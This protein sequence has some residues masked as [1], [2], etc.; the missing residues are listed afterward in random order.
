MENDRETQSIMMNIRGAGAMM[1]GILLFNNAAAVGTVMLLSTFI[2]RLANKKLLKP[3]E[4]KNLDA[5]IRKTGGTYQIYNIPAISKEQLADELTKSGLQFHVLPDLNKNDGIIQVAIDKKD[6][7]K[8]NPWFERHILANL[9][10]G[11]HSRFELE[12]LTNNN[13]SIISVP[14]EE[15]VELLRK[16]FDTL[17]INYTLLPDLRVGDGEIQLMVA[18][19]DLQKAQHWYKLYQEGIIKLNPEAEVGELRV[20]TQEQYTETAR[21]T[22]KEYIKNADPQYQAANKEFER[23]PGELELTAAIAGSAQQKTTSDIE[24]EQLKND[25]AF[26]EITINKETLVE[27]SSYGGFKTTSAGDLFASRIPGTYGD[28]ELTMVIDAEN[29]FETD[30]GLT[31][32]AFLHKDEKPI[33]LDKDGKPISPERK[34]TGSEIYAKHYEKVE[35]QFKNKERVAEKGIKSLKGTNELI[36]RTPTNPM[37]RK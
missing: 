33:M 24:Y 29:V 37:K 10:G 3:G 27:N 9:K 23:E 1:K 32:I 35:R 11:E 8:F 2:K 21:T 17:G 6:K 4:V 31:Y 15:K 22:E 5:F 7:D 26:E 25:I 20:I 28:S 16:D 34:L 18:N 30:D 19:A 36:P 14:M 13:L 12:N